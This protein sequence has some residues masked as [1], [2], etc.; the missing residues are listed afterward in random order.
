ML[1]C[2]VREEK[3]R[4]PLYLKQEEAKYYKNFG[5]GNR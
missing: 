5:P 1:T 3:E 4:K 2:Y